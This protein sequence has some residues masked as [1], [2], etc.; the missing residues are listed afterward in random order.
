MTGAGRNVLL[1]APQ[2]TVA[3]LDNIGSETERFATVTASGRNLA[4]AGDIWTNGDILLSIGTTSSSTANDFLQFNNFLSVA[5]STLAPHDTRLD[6]ATG[7]IVLGSGAVA[8]T[9]AKTAAPARASIFKS[10]TGDLYLL[11]RKVTVQPF[12]RL[13]VRD[14]SLIIIA[15]GETEGNSGITLSSTAA[16]KYLVLASSAPI[17]IPNAGTSILIRSRTSADQVVTGVDGAGTI[18]PDRGTEL[19][20]GKVIFYGKGDGVSPVPAMPT[21]GFFKPDN[22]ATP[23]T[24]GVF[25]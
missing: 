8:G 9:T 1:T 4:V 17:K 13:A 16:S 23:T 10:N 24:A 15:D 14:G 5:G 19:I 12:E 18:I 6:S 11:A 25:N 20:A 21:R 3:T 2:S 7:Q 22:W